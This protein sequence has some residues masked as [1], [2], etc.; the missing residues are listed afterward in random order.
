MRPRVWSMLLLPISTR[1]RFDDGRVPRRIELRGNEW[2]VE[3]ANATSIVPARGL[4]G[5][6]QVVEQE[7]HDVAGTVEDRFVGEVGE[8]ELLDSVDVA[9]NFLGAAL[10]VRRSVTGTPGEK[11]PLGPVASSKNVSAP[12]WL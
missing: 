4:V 2:A 11:A 1:R 7:V 8:T 5:S 6:D 10:R 3:D 12:F 9:D